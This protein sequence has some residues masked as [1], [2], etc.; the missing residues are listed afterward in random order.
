MVWR[1]ST[2][3]T[4]LHMQAGE[5]ARSQLAVNR[6]I[7][8]RKLA[9]VRGHLQPRTYCPDL[10][11]P[12]LG[13]IHRTRRYGDELLRCDAVPEPG[14]EALPCEMECSRLGNRKSADFNPRAV[15]Q[16]SILSRVGGRG[17]DL[18]LHGSLRFLLQHG[19]PGSDL[20]SVTHAS[21]AA[22]SGALALVPRGAAAVKGIERF[23]E[24]LLS[25]AGRSSLHF[26]KWSP[27][28]PSIDLRLLIIQMT[29]SEG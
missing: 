26:F 16:A 9:D 15:I 8:H 5:V 3:P 23:H 12:S 25:K 29:A 1:R 17:R 2:C 19:R 10:A 11:K 6:E 18:E 20:V 7:E 14:Q 4:V 13:C 27:I 24:D 22:S 21:M 28:G